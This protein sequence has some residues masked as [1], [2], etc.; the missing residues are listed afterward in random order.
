MQKADEVGRVTTGP[1]RINPIPF[2][3][4]LCLILAVFVGVVAG[5]IAGAVFFLFPRLSLLAFL[6]FLAFLSFFLARAVLSPIS[7][8]AVSKETG[9]AVPPVTKLRKAKLRGCDGKSFFLVL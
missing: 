3:L 8:D 1:E 7:K 5:L 4:C 9:T 2:F 6:P